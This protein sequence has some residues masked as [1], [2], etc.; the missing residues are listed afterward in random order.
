MFWTVTLK[1]KIDGRIVTT[2]CN[3][4]DEVVN[5]ILH[6]DTIIYE[7]VSIVKDDGYYVKDYKDVCYQNKI[8]ETGKE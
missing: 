1:E 4:K 8:I 6:L 7:L 3:D 5:L 2:I